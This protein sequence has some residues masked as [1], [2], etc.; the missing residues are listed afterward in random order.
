MVATVIY[1]PSPPEKCDTNN[2][3]RVIPTTKSCLHQL[4]ENKLKV[5]LSKQETLYLM[6]TLVDKNILH[7]N[8]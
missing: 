7:R 3:K 6:L 8:C 5:S 2:S 4:G 1:S